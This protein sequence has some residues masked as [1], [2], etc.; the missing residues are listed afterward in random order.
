MANTREKINDADFYFK[1]PR[2][3]KV[4][5]QKEASRRG[6]SYAEFV[7]ITLRRELKR[8]R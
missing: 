2:A 6:I 5:F 7:R 3:L 4:R 1:L 8:R